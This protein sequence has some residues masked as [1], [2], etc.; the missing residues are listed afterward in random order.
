MPAPISF[1]GMAW[2]YERYAKVADAPLY[3]LERHHHACDA[4]QRAI[5][6][7]RAKANNNLAG[8]MYEQSVATEAAAAATRCDTRG[9]ELQADVDEARRLCASR[10][11]G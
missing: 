1:N 9:R 2:V 4:Q 7:Q 3:R 10:G 6:A 5:L 8:A 11:C